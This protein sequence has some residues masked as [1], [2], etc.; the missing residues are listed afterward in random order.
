MMTGWSWKVKIIRVE[1]RGHRLH[2]SYAN[3][4]RKTPKTMA[5]FISALGIGR[6]P[7][8]HH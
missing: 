5:Q 4:L 7:I 8:S 1:R 2:G 6:R 3:K